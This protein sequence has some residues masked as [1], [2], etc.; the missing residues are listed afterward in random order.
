MD[1]IFNL[2]VATLASSVYCPA[3][4]YTT[5]N[6]AVSHQQMAKAAH[7]RKLSEFVHV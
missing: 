1:T 7:R 2:F 6:E 5:E 3:K 4:F